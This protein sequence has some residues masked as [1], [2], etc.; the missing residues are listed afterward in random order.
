MTLDPTTELP[1]SPPADSVTQH[2]DAQDEMRR[3]AVRDGEHW[4]STVPPLVA[5]TAL[6]AAANAYSAAFESSRHQVGDHL[7]ALRSAIAAASP[8]LA[9]W[10]TS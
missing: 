5:R 6:D 10:Y 4:E 8:I 1:T 7:R 3:I 9:E 2:L